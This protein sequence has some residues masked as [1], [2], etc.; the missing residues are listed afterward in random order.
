MLCIVMSPFLRET[1]HLHK[2]LICTEVLSLLKLH[3]CKKGVKV[4]FVLSDQW[5]VRKTSLFSCTQS[6]VEES[7]HAW[8][9]ALQPPCS[10]LGIKAPPVVYFKEIIVN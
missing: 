5:Y 8:E 10:I 3:V 1:H 2:L 9:R 4:S 6:R 7:N